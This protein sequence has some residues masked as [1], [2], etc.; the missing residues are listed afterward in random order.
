MQCSERRRDAVRIHLVLPDASDKPIVDAVGTADFHEMLHL[1][2]K[3]HRWGPA[4]GWSASRMLHTKAWLIDYEP[5]RGGLAY[6]GAANATQRSHLSDNE[7][8]ILTR[9]PEFAREVYERLFVPDIA[10]DSRLE[11]AEGFHVVW[12][13]NPVVRAS[14]WL[15]RLLVDL[16]WF[17]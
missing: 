14:R 16:L 15:R 2:I 13:S 7:A 6:V 9:S 8:G 1:G 10:A 5:G 12:S 11:G 4:S 17:I 3:I